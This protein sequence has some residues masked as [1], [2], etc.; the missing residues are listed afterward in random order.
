MK[1]L[2]SSCVLGN[3]VRWNGAN[4][5]SDFIQ[6]WA[7]DNNITLIPVCPE[8]RL[9]GVPRRPIR[10]TQNGPVVEAWAGDEEVYDSLEDT[11]RSILNEHPDLCGFIGLANS[12]TCGMSAGV[13]KRGATIRGAM[14]RVTDVPT[15]EVNQLRD[16]RGRENF[17]NRLKKCRS[18]KIMNE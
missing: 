17:L 8:Q 9:L 10:M 2:I 18:N 14:H 13:R 12:P 5:K 16:E 11:S 3:P 7:Q 4:K 6:D 1:V 15:C